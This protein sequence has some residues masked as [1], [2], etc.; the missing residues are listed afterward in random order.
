MLQLIILLILSIIYLVGLGLTLS[1]LIP[2]VRP[3]GTLIILTVFWPV[4]LI[5]FRIGDL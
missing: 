1:K 2:I 3:T 4:T 5:F